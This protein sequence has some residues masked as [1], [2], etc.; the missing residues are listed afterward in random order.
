MRFRA[1]LQKIPLTPRTS[2]SVNFRYSSG[3]CCFFFCQRCTVLYLSHQNTSQKL[4]LMNGFAQGL[5]K[6]ILLGA[7]SAHMAQERKRNKSGISIFWWNGVSVAVCTL[8]IPSAH[9]KPLDCV[10]FWR[11]AKWLHFFGIQ[12]LCENWYVTENVN[13]MA[14]RDLLWYSFPHPRGPDAPGPLKP[15]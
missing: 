3:M 2:I 8:Y 7:K 4:T 9:A 6:C 14:W 5:Q 12:T 11:C 1:I 13:K 15:M 10:R